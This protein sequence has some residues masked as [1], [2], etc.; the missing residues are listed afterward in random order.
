MISRRLYFQLLA[1]ICLI[2]A[3]SLAFAFFIMKS[4]SVKWSLLSGLL[5]IAATTNLISFQNKTNTNIRLFFDAV[6]NDDSSLS[7]PQEGGNTTINAINA[8]MNRINEQVK[9]LKIENKVRE[10]YFGKILEHLATGIV[11]YD[12]NGFIHN[13]NSAAR[14]LLGMEVLTHLKQLERVDQGLYK[15]V[16]GIREQERQLV[17]INRKD[18][19]TGLLLHSAQAGELM[20]L[21]IQDIKRELDEKEVDAWIRLIRVL[22]HEIMNS[23]APITSLSDT[24]SGIYRKEG[25]QISASEIT[26]HE[27]SRTLQGLNVI[28]EQSR[29]LLEFVESYRKLTRI[30]KP[31]LK[32][33]TVSAL[34]ERV[35]LLT[36]SL[37]KGTGTSIIF[38]DK[39]TD[40]EILAD[41]NLVTQVLLNLVK[42]SIEALSGKSSGSIEVSAWVTGSKTVD[43]CVKDNGPGISPELIDEIFIPFFTTKENGSGIGLSISRQIMG[44]HGGSLKARSVPGTE[45]IF[46]MSF[47]N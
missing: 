44:A 32:L 10:Q 17:S 21:T 6:K 12:K 45:T 22:M 33:I 18:G 30:P 11:T 36:D 5:L 37:E 31:E 47:R 3:L 25:S 42:N 16:S 2:T 39:N 38:S 8:G 27:I 43:L 24:L 19:E 40:A 4:A 20:I 7:F 15:A 13:V 28:S 14:K 41:E 29:G 35:K 26:D 9:K 46:C 1:R 34:F 23:I